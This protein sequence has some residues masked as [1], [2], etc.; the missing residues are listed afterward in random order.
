VALRTATYNPAVFAHTLDR[1]G[2]IE[3]N[4]VADL[5]LLEANPLDDIRNTRK[6]AGVVRAGKFYSREDLDRMLE[7]AAKAAAAQ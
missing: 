2:T 1:Y 4:R 3:T 6:I 5:V 7:L